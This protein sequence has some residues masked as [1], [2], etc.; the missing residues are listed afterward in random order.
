MNK[1]EK[2]KPFK[3]I[4]LE[5]YVDSKLY[6]WDFGD[7]W[8]DT[9][10]LKSLKELKDHRF[11]DTK[12]PKS[13]TDEDKL[14]CINKAYRDA[15]EQSYMSDYIEKFH[16]R[17]LTKLNDVEDCKLSFDYQENYWD[18]IKLNVYAPIEFLVGEIPANEEFKSITGTEEDY[19][20]FEDYLIEKVDFK[21]V[22]EYV[23]A[24]MHNYQA[25]DSN[26]F[27]EVYKERMKDAIREVKGEKL[28]TYQKVKNELDKHIS[29]S[30]KVYNIIKM[31]QNGR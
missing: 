23:R 21:Q 11:P 16:E 1:N 15:D 20:T 10:G 2:I 17:L 26:V 14:E 24:H 8:L 29:K 27:D 18:S 12:F 7:F 13:F 28:S 30:Q 22:L 6:T 4:N 5:D 25:Y 19:R 3:V 9:P 31:V